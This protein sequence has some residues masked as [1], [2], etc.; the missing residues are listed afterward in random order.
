MTQSNAP[1]S[2]LL[3]APGALTAAE[4]AVSACHRDRCRGARR[5]PALAFAV[6][7]V[8]AGGSNAGYAQD[9]ELVAAI[10][11]TGYGGHPYG[12]AAPSC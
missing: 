6:L 1:T 3:A 11:R 12:W 5:L 2:P 10:T 7:I 4:R 9:G 8:L